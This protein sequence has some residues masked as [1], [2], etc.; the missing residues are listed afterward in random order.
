MIPELQIGET[1]SACSKYVQALASIYYD[2]YAVDNHIAAGS[3]SYHFS[4]QMPDIL[5]H[6]FGILSVAACQQVRLNLRERV[7]IR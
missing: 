2:I 6:T 4:D 5:I 7:V 1:I 3:I